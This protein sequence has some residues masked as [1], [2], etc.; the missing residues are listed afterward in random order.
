M[1]SLKSIAILMKKNGKTNKCLVHLLHPMHL[2]ANTGKE[3]VIRMAQTKIRDYAKL[4]RDIRD[5]LGEANIVSAA[6]CATRLRLVLKETPSAETTKKIS[7]MPAVIQVVEKGGQYQIVIGTHAKDVYEELSGILSLDENTAP[8]KQGIIA[9][10][11]A[12]MSAV[13]APFVYI[14][15]AAGL[16]QGA[17][18]ILNQ[19][20]PSFSQSEPMKY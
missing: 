14:L 18:I 10:I 6:H 9:G 12:T 5:T 11:I 15:A 4:A 3:K 8:V 16:L 1:T 13:F 2:L 19:F 20:A 7:E 17:L